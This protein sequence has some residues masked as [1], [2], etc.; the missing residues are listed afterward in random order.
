MYDFEATE[1]FLEGDEGNR[2]PTGKKQAEKQ[3]KIF[4]V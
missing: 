2:E 1:M 4:T 3:G